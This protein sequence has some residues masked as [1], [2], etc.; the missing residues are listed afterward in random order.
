[1]LPLHSPMVLLILQFVIL[2]AQLF[3]RTI[4]LFFS[5]RFRVVLSQLPYTYANIR[6]QLVVYVQKKNTEI[7][8]TP[9][10]SILPYFYYNRNILFFSASSTISSG[11][12]E[13]CT[14][15][16]WAFLKKYIHIRDCPIPPPTEYG[17]FPS[18][19]AF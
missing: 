19:R 18:K 3:W 1:M 16:I 7:W 14:S 2:E 12:M 15:P 6:T 11:H 13:A 4:N 9:F 10:S 17:S 5:Y 8:H